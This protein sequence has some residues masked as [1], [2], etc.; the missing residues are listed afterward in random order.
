M[1][2][3]TFHDLILEVRQEGEEIGEGLTQLLPELSLVRT[4][5]SGRKA[6][7]CLC[8]RPSRH[9][10]RVPLSARVVFQAEGFSGLEEGDD[11]YLTDGS[12]LFHLQAARGWGDAQL[13]PSFFTKPVVLQ[14]NFWAF[15]LLKLLRPL[16][17]YSLHAAGVVTR[18]G[19]GLLIVGASGSGKSTLT[20]GLIRQGWGYLSDDAVL[21]R[22][23]SEEVEALAFR[24]NFYIDASAAIAHSDLPLGEEAPDTSGGRKRRVCIE[25]AYP[26][27]Q[28]AGCIPRVLLF[29][30]IVPRA[31]ST[32]LPLDRLSALK[33]LLAGSGPQLF[34]RGTMSEHLGVLQRL[35]QQTAT[36]ELEAGLDLYRQ[37]SQ[38]GHFLAEVEGEGKWPA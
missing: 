25:A 16:G 7:L 33:R 4:H 3:Y 34:D 6:S 11:F 1:I 22:F 26:Q 17:L 30:R 20:L 13:A 2:L 15:G 14:R 18:E 9:E 38:L 8:V 35:V 29:S 24:K 5:A 28:A 21:L 37:P 27:Q 31:H 12:S 19:R 32:L 36:Y 10:L 23:H